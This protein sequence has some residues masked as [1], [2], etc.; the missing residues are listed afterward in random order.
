MGSHRLVCDLPARHGRGH[1]RRAAAAQVEVALLDHHVPRNH[2]M[3]PVNLIDEIQGVGFDYGMSAREVADKVRRSTQP[4]VGRR[5]RVPRSATAATSC[6][7]VPASG[8]RGRSCQ[9]RRRLPS[10]IP[11]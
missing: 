2:G 6:L 5:P 8:L 4:G 11:D 9:H 3:V 7:R 1:G 10:V